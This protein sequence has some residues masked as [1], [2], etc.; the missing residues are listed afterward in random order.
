MSDTEFE[1]SANATASNDPVT[2]TFHSGFT[3]KGPSIDTY[4]SINGFSPDIGQISF[5]QTNGLF[6]K[7]ATVCNMRTFI[8]HS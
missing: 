5:G 2:L 8:K 4:E 6:Y 3:I 7:T 1:L